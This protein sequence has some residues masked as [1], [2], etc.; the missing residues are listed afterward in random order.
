MKT[1]TLAWIVLAA[2]LAILAAV[3]ASS[4]RSPEPASATPGLLAPGLRDALNDLSQV[5][6]RSAGD[7]TL[8]T[9][10][11]GP[12]GWGLQEKSAYP[13]DVEKLAELLSMIAEARRV[14]ARTA[15]PARHAQLGVE[16][17]SDAQ[18]RGVLV[19][20]T[21][22]NTTWAILF[23]D[24]PVRG[25]GTHVRLAGENQSWLID[26]SIAIE[27]KPANWLDKRIIDV[28]ANRIAAV[29]IT[30]VEGAAFGLRREA[31]DARSD[32]TLEGVPAKREAAENYQREALA[33]VL[34]GL[35]FEDVFTAAERSRPDRVRVS[36]F[37]LDDGRRVRLDS[38]VQDGRTLAQVS[39]SLDEVVAEEWLERPAAQ[40]EAAAQ[41]DADDE[42]ATGGTASTL[43]DLKEQVARFQRERVAW[44]YQLPAYKASN[45]NKDLEDYLKPRE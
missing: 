24:N 37:S 9:L 10:Q 4:S 8:A 28:G 35:N 17:I 36:I 34:S 29:S 18:A 13:V 1:R 40:A 43:A 44:V 45:L 19:E 21:A 25:T 42:T 2:I 33:G 6:I 7:T 15:L 16:D 20:L 41:A 39:M 30:P 5:R 32:F 31:G 22:G 23:G 26:K 12:D 3:W 27:R 11:R 38:W 14:E